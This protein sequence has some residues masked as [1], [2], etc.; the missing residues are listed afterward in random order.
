VC[1][2]AQLLV[3]MGSQALFSGLVS[4]YD[5]LNVNLPRSWDCRCELQHSA[6][7]FFRDSE[8]GGCFLKVKKAN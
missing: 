6:S 2:Q 8:G 5:P 1:H 3:D 4:N 7:G